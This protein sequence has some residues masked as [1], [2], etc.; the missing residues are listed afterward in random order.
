MLQT[1]AG[2]TSHSNVCRVAATNGNDPARRLNLLGFCR[3][4]D[5]LSEVVESTVLQH[6]GAII[7]REQQL[8]GLHNQLRLSVA[9][10]LLWGIPPQHEPLKAAILHGG[11][12]VEKAWKEW[13]ML[14]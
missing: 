3:C 8:K 7:L 13:H 5:S 2:P 14:R 10:P 6:G 9:I 11:G 1:A 12:F 4:I